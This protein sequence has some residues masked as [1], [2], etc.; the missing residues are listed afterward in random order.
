VP[1]IARTLG[2]VLISRPPKAQSRREDRFLGG[3]ALVVITRPRCPSRGHHERHD[4]PRTTTWSSLDFPF[5]V[6][7]AWPAQGQ[8]SGG[9][10]LPACKSRLV[11]A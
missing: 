6:T 10:S 8:G 1:V 3:P 2:N 5:A 11:L 9:F 7:A 4:A